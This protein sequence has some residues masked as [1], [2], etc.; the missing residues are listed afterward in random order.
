MSQHDDDW[1]TGAKAI[2]F[3]MQCSVDTVYRYANNPAAPIYKPNGRYAA[4]RSEL[5]AWRK[6]KPSAIGRQTLQGF[7]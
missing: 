6:T 1:I 5:H 7:A 2:A 4:R 3:E